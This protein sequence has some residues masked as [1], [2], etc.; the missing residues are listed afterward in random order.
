MRAEFGK[1]ISHIHGI[2]KRW[3]NLSVFREAGDAAAFMDS[4]EF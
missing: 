2:G 3:R 1:A 4:V